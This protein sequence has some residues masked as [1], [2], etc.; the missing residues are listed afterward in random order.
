MKNGAIGA[1][2][3]YVTADKMIPMKP[4]APPPRVLG[5]DTALAFSSNS[6]WCSVADVGSPLIL[7]RFFCVQNI[8]H[9]SS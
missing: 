2:V 6:R 9:D 5:N 4:R 3:A 1:R 8:D 7:V